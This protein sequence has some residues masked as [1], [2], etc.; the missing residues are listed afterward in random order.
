[1]KNKSSAG[2]TLIELVVA[3]I[4]SAILVGFVAMLVSTPIEAY[5]DQSERA[6]ITQSAQTI[7][8]S[9]S[10][11][12][13]QGVLPNSVRISDD[14][15]TMELIKVVAVSYYVPH[16]TFAAMMP[17]QSHP[18]V[19]LQVG[20][21]GEIFHLF[22]PM[23]ANSGLLVTGHGV[24][25]LDAYETSDIIASGF[26]IQNQSSGAHRVELTGSEKFAAAD[27][28]GRVFWVSEPVTYICNAGAKMLRRFSGYQ[29]NSDIASS[30][31]SSHLSSGRNALV[32]E[33]LESC[34]FSC[35]LGPPLNYC[36][37]SVR[38]EATVVRSTSSGNETIR[39]LE[40]YALD[41]RS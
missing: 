38:F 3:M 34:A 7:S 1:M 36:E 16:G 37:D 14:G 40:Q 8:R 22:G 11:D 27:T 18:D 32:T 35:A 15:S 26:D 2:F 31:A 4:V 39:I 12:L 17:A 41:N 19:E 29:I 23:G 24:A 9:L 25:G 5:I 33:G 21:S 6:A 13:G 10:R 20:T 30:E 28:L